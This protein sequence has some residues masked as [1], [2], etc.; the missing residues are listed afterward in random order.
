[1]PNKME[2][3]LHEPFEF[4]PEKLV[5]GGDALGHH[6]GGTIL[7]PLALPGERVRAEVNRIAK[8]VVRARVMEV[9]APSADRVQPPCPYFGRCGGCQL[10]HLRDAVQPEAKREIL[11]ETL[12]RLGKVQWDGEIPIHAAAPW[13][14]RNQAQLKVASLQNGGAE[15]GFFASES[16]RLI[17]IENCAILS[18]RLNLLLD[19]L[20]RPDWPG[21][22]GKC[23]EI[24]LLADDRDASVMMTI[25]GLLSK[26]EAQALASAMFEKSLK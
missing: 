11:R 25:H 26:S 16:H 10:Q 20:R 19:A 9:L 22:I 17:P 13:G 23:T 24:D 3:L 21:W 1:M 8:G 15:V 4:T 5:Y 6:A 18:P 12:R 14:Y 2:T 7:V